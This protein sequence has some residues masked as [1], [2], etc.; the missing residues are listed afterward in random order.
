MRVRSLACPGGSVSRVNVLLALEETGLCACLP[1]KR[2]LGRKSCLPW[3]K[4][5]RALACPGEVSMLAC[6]G[7]KWSVRLLAR[8]EG[9]G[10]CLGLGQ[11]LLAREED[12]PCAC[13]PGTRV[14][15]ARLAAWEG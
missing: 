1:W 7:R 15:F 14:A 11:V 9:R 6:P 12:G 5:N 10:R 3:R 4:M 13:L 8:E 2:I